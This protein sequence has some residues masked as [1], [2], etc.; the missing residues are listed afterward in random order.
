MHMADGARVKNWLQ[1]RRHKGVK[2]IAYTVAPLRRAVISHR[3][4]C[5]SCSRYAVSQGYIDDC[6]DEFIDT[7]C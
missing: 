6:A 2:G 5:G 7:A 4:L 1:K 3:R